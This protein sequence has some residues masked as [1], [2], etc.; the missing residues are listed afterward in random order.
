MKKLTL[1]VLVIFTVGLVAVKAQV[2]T[3]SISGTALDENGSGLPGT[4][5]QAVHTPSGTKYGTISLAT[6]RFTLPNMRIGGPYEIVISFVG[7]QDA[8]YS[9]IYLRLGE[10]FSLNV[11]MQTVSICP[12]CSTSPSGCPHPASYS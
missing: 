11:Q 5:I 1:S 7:F 10:E 2:T 3:S 4:T 6:G 9:D 12:D 8:T